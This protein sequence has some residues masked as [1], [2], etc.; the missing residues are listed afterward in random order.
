MT[1]LPPLSLP[2]KIL[3]L[4]L[5]L[6]LTGIGAGFG[7]AASPAV[8]IVILGAIATMALFFWG[9]SYVLGQFAASTVSGSDGPNSLHRA[10]VADR[11]PLL[12]LALILLAFVLLSQTVSGFFNIW[13]VISLLI[14]LAILVLTR[15]L[16]RQFQQNCPAFIGIMVLAGLLSVGSMNIEGFASGAIIAVI[17]IVGMRITV[18]GRFLY[19]VGVNRTSASRVMISEMRYWVLMYA[20]SGFFAAMTGSLLLGWSGASS[21]SA[22]S[23]CS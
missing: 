15:T 8:Q 6:I 11:W 17:L 21:A 2:A 4:I 16:G 20:A 12:G 19:A 14:L 9:W 3:G 1:P 10:W 7:F 18:Y 23:I 13:N 5:G 22:T